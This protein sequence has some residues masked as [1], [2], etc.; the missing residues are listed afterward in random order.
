MPF[1]YGVEIWNGL[2]ML[3]YRLGSKIRTSIH[4]VKITDVS[5]PYWK[6]GFTIIEVKWN[7]IKSTHNNLRGCR[8]FSLGV[9]FFFFFLLEAKICWIPF[10][11]GFFFMVYYCVWFFSPIG[12]T[13]MLYWIDICR[14]QKQKEKSRRN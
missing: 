4:T 5:N 9:F 7:E 13:N 8:C 6:D 1:I 10:F 11:T 3:W 2:L 12:F 14:G